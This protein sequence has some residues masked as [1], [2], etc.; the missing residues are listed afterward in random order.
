MFWICELLKVGFLQEKR[1]TSFV[2]SISDYPYL[3]GMLGI[4]TMAPLCRLEPD[5]SEMIDIEPEAAFLIDKVGWG[6]FF[7]EFRWS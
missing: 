2:V 6:D 7:Q 1:V 4:A 3:D 5:G